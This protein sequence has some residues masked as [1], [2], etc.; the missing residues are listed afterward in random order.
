MKRILSLLILALLLSVTISAYSCDTPG[1]PVDSLNGVIWA[2]QPRYSYAGMFSCGLTNVEDPSFSECIVNKDGNPCN[3]FAGL[4]NFTRNS[5]TPFFRN[6]I[7]A[8]SYL[9]PSEFAYLT[10][11]GTTFGENMQVYFPMYFDKDPLTPSIEDGTE[12]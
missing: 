3:G 4:S 10:R 5:W 7:A 11:S 8:S 6:G 12:L 9:S 1:K 2:I